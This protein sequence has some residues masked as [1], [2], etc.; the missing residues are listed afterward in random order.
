M[1]YEVY[2]SNVYLHNGRLAVP[3]EDGDDGD[4]EEDAHTR[5]ADRHDGQQR[6]PAHVLHLEVEAAS[7]VLVRPPARTAIG[8]LELVLHI[9]PRIAAVA[10]PAARV[11][12]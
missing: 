8:A 9:L 12:L 2:R 10:A 11:T 7:L 1:L 3:D 4:G 6:V 5:D